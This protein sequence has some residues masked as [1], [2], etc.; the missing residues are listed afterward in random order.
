MSFVTTIKNSR[1]WQALVGIQRLILVATSI[2]VV[3]IMCTAVLLRYVF[4]AD[5][6]GIEEIVVI[7][8]FWLY[9]V[10]SAYGVYERS[11]VKADIIPQFL[12]PRPRMILNLIVQFTI[13]VLCVVFTVWA[14][15]MVRHSLTWMPRTTGL[16]I[17]IVVSQSSILAGYILMSFY[18]IVYFFDDLMTAIIGE[19]PTDSEDQEKP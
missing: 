19:V 6:F 10:G 7:A 17:P 1:F 5:L 3:L 16:R 8:A 9:L 14:V 13:A 11:H 12:R 4:K 18:S 2:F 15:D